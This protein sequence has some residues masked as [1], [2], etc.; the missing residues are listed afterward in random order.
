MGFASCG[1]AARWARR[2][3]AELIAVGLVMASGTSTPAGALT[4]PVVD[5]SATP[6]DAPPAPDQ[7]MRMIQSCAVTGALPGA[8]LGATPIGQSFMNLPALWQSAGKGAGVTV[9]MI[10][11]GVNRSPRLPHLRGAGDYIVADGDGLSDCDSHGTVVASIIGAAPSETDGL[12][13]VAPDAELISIRQSS[14]AFQP[15]RPAPT[16]TQTDRRAGT[17]GTLARAVVHAANAGARVI[18]MSVVACVPVL[19]PVDQNSL[20]AA[21]RYAAVDHDVVLVS[22]AG[23]LGSPGCAQNPDV[24]PARPADSRNWAGVVTVSTPSWFSDYVLSVSATDGAGAPAV[25][26]HGREI[27]LSGPWVGV[28]APGIF[29]EA[30]TDR[31]QLINATLDSQAGVMRSMSGTSFSAAYVSG[32]A[33][34]VRA[35][36]PNLSAAQVIRRIERTAHSPSDVVDN[37]IGYGTVD[38]VAALNDDVAIGQRLP[39]E[40]ATRKLILPAPAPAP[41]RRPMATALIGSSAVIA[42]AALVF[43]VLRLAGHDRRPRR[44][45]ERW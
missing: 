13:G 17:V 26:D 32:L 18:N 20:G 8:D 2:C 16:D 43:G 37:R 22:A 11:T 44:G 35:K 6:P 10:D 45:A 24:D 9:A 3:G 33:A 21:L 31:G 5:P 38:P 23:N 19:K 1:C 4:A 14:D 27:S 15:E 41:D 25:D 40:H 39:T 42:L 12:A 28:G 34:L 29:V 36:Y 7:P 30:V